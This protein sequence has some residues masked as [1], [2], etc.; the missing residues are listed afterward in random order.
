MTTIEPCNDPGVLARLC[1]IL[2]LAFAA[3]DG[4]IDPPSGAHRETPASLAAK[5]ESET[6]LVAREGDEIAGCIFCTMQS[7][8]EAYIGRLAVDPARQ[9]SGI[10]RELLLA[11]IAWAREQGA[12]RVGLG[13]R[14]ELAENIAFFRRHGFEITRAESHPGYERPTNYHMELVLA[15]GPEA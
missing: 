3:H 11:A 14:V 15:S 12:D 4:R 9:G 10:A 6:L 13:V 7:A 2:D 5:L 8:D 1:Q